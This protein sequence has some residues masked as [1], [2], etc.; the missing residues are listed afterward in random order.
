VF[1][2]GDNVTAGYVNRPEANTESFDELGWFR[3]GDLGYL[4]EHG[5]LYLVGRIKEIINRG[6]EKIS[7]AEVDAALLE[8]PGI[9]EAVTFGMP[10]TKYGEEV[11]LAVVKAASFKGEITEQDVIKFCSSRL[12]KIKVPT[13]VFVVDAIPKSSIGKVQR[14]NLTA[15]FGKLMASTSKL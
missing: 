15:H 2:R 14:K 7:P 9:G 12:A 4:D 1:E 8:M 5:Y 10:S 6:G 11:Y 3:T 13:K